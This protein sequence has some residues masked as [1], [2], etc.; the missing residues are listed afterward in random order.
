MNNEVKKISTIS[1]LSALGMV[2]ML[3]EIPYFIGGLNFDISDVVVLVAFMMFGWKEA[4]LVGALKALIH[5]LLK[6][7]FGP[8]YIG[9][10]TAFVSSGVLVLGMWISVVKFKWNKYYSALFT[11]ALVTVLLT[12]LNY[13]FVTPIY[14]MFFVTGEASFATF[15]DVREFNGEQLFGLSPKLNYL[16]TIVVLFG[17]FNII[18]GTILFAIFIAIKDQL[19]TYLKLNQ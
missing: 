6:P 12:A 7:A 10:I 11:I 17:S 1:I 4:L 19:S 18:K 5:A 2:L 3:I 16:S 9:E 13:F 8:V 15:V 14:S